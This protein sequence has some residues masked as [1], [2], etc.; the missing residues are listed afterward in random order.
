MNQLMA[1]DYL[2]RA[3]LVALAALAL[4]GP[5]TGAQE[6]PG[7]AAPAPAGALPAPGPAAA[8]PSGSAPSIALEPSR[9]RPGDAF[10]VTVRGVAEAPQ[11]EVLGRPLRFY[12]VAGGFQALAGLSVEASP[13]LLPIAVAAAGPAG[14]ATLAAELELAEPAFAETEIRVAQKFITPPPEARRRMKRDQTAFDRAFA[15]AFEPPLYRERFAWPRQDELTARYGDRRIFNGQ[16][17]SQHYGVDLAGRSGDPVAAAN[18][19][20]VVLVRD[21]YGS[22]K[23]VV[24]WHGAGLYSV[25]FHLSRFAVQEGARVR[26]GDLLGRVGQTGRATGPHL[27]WGTKLDGLYVDPESVLRLAPG[28]EATPAAAR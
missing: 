10:L 23:S 18:D 3:R 11:G 13:G 4:A 25:Y 24:V 16:K 12:P 9:V 22:G 5:G 6:P 28:D 26:R 20:L 21:C 8:G 1:G 7:A 17:L 27:H 14:E 2:H 15:Q 19:G